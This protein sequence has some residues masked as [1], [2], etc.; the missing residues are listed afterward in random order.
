MW[1][2]KMWSE[3]VMLMDSPKNNLRVQST[4]WSTTNRLNIFAEANWRRRCH[5]GEKGSE[6]V[7]EGEARKTN[8]RGEGVEEREEADKKEGMTWF[9]S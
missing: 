4:S 6:C 9:E 3:N 1:F 5:W 8:G 2:D 7:E